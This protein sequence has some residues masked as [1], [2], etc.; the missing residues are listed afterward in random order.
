MGTAPALGVTALAGS[1]GRCLF[2]CAPFCSADPLCSLRC[3]IHQCWQHRQFQA[4]AMPFPRGKKHAGFFRAGRSTFSPRKFLV[5]L[6]P[7]AKTND[8]SPQ[9][10]TRS[11]SCNPVHLQL[12]SKL[13]GQARPRRVPAA[14]AITG[15]RQAVAALPEAGWAPAASGRCGHR[16]APVATLTGT[17]HSDAVDEL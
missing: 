14:A 12:R 6:C 13:R 2:V 11:F 5:S 17:Q 8:A 7:S 4:S 1:R 10:W 9:L 16:C 3:A 15:S